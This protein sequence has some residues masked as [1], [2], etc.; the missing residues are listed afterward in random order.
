MPAISSHYRPSSI[1]RSITSHTTISVLPPWPLMVLDAIEGK[2]L[3]VYGRGANVRDWLFV[4]DHVAALVAAFE[5]GRPGGTFLIG[6]NA[7]RDSLSVVRA[8][9]DLV[10]V[11][12]GTSGTSDG[13]GCSPARIAANDWG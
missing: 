10:D 9:C 6:A 8:I 3:P 4:E 7:E 11:F 5:R 2:P 13:R 12:R 1:T